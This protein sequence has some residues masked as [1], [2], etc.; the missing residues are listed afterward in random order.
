MVFDLSDLRDAAKRYAGHFQGPHGSWAKIAWEGKDEPP[1][2]RL[3]DLVDF[4]GK[5]KALRFRGGGDAFR[6]IYSAWLGENR[7]R[8]E[9]VHGRVLYRLIPADFETILQVSLSFRSHGAPPT[10]FGKALHFLLPETV[11]LWDQKVVRDTYGLGSEPKD[12]GL[13]ALRLE[14]AT[15]RCRRSRR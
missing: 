4:L 9:S 10:T 8:V 3:D 1:E 14:T 15:P 6:R 11:M 5:G 13:P 7:R 2:R 12:F